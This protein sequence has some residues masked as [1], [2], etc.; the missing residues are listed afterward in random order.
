MDRD[1]LLTEMFLEYWL[2]DIKPDFENPPANSP[3]E[4]ILS[5]YQGKKEDALSAYPWRSATRYAQL[6]LKV[7]EQSAD[8]RYKYEANVPEDFLIAIGFWRDKERR[9]DCMNSVDIVGK[10]ARTNETSITMG[11]TKKDVDEDELDPWVI[12][13]I[14]LVLAAD[15][16]DIGGVPID[17]K[18]YLLQ[19][20]D[21]E[22]IKLGNK[23]YEMAHKDEISSSIHQFEWS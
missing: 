12:E 18:N 2:W 6:E 7:P 19:R 1:T 5:L 16:A 8:G 22:L 13:Y 9:M 4:F 23:D 20:K 17:R 14:K 10:K 21:V 3:E 15:L 11:Y